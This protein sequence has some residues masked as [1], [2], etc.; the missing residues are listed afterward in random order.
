MDLSRQR[1]IQRKRIL[2]GIEGVEMGSEDEI[3]TDLEV[4]QESG[5]IE[6]QGIDEK[7][8][9]IYRLSELGRFVVGELEYNLDKIKELK[10]ILPMLTDDEIKRQN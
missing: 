5:L 10:R 7:G 4:L 8:K 1:N 3:L 6:I 9:W 2:C